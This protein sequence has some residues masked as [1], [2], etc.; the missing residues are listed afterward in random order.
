[1]L[2]LAARL[3]SF[4]A[5]CVE[6]ELVPRCDSTHNS[7]R[8]WNSFTWSKTTNYFFSFHAFWLCEASLTVC[9]VNTVCYPTSGR[10]VSQTPG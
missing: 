9:T 6:T 2:D 8:L 1:H 10:K 3:V 5:V 7:D 4:S